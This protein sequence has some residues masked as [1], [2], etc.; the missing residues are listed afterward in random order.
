MSLR[1]RLT[2]LFGWSGLLV[3]LPMVTATVMMMVMVVR[4]RCYSC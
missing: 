4:T 3:M 1:W 2:R